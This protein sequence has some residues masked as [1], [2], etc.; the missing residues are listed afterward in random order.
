MKVYFVYEGRLG[1]TRADS[2]YVA[3]NAEVT[4][5]LADFGILNSRRT[6]WTL[7][8]GLINQFEIT[9]LGKPFDPKN[10]FQSIKGQILFGFAIRKFLQDKN[11]HPCVLIFHNWWALQALHFVKQNR[12]SFLFVLEVHD[13]LPLGGLWPRAFGHIDL[14]IAT[15]QRKFKELIPYFGKKVVLEKNCVR[16]SRY[17]YKLDQGLIKNQWG[18][19]SKTFLLG[20]TGS[21]GPE[22]NPSFIA[23]CATMSKDTFLIAGNIPSHLQTK[24][25]S[26]TNVITLGPVG[27]EEI[28]RVQIGCDALLITLDPKSEQSRLYTS[29]MKLMEYV[30]AKRP[31]IAPDLPSILELL[32]ES[33]FYSFQ[34]DSVDSFMEAVAKLKSDMSR[35]KVR[36]PRPTRV[37]EYS[38]VERNKRLLARFDE[39]LGSPVGRNSRA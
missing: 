25:A 21:F 10:L 17:R 32:D 19:T 8:L 26:L 37:K 23:E 16:T 6:N 27:R 33:E 7:P 18:L 22:K 35:Q 20:Y 12:D 3:E 2:T 24:Y 5:S 4:K 30:A 15:N 14:F 31:I 28:P 38:W 36:L 13:Q 29:T 39:M 1:S 11:N 9:S 34:A